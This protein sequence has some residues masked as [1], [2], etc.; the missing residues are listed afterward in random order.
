M[1]APVIDGSLAEWQWYHRLDAVADGAVGY[2]LYGQFSGGNYVFAIS[3]PVAITNATTIWLDTDLNTATGYQVFGT[4]VGAEY[5][6]N[7]VGGLPYLYTGAAAQNFVSGPLTH[8]FSG[9][10]K[11]LEVS[12]PASSIGST[13]ALRVF[14]DVNDSVFLPND[15]TFTGY[16]VEAL[17][18]VVSDSFTGSNGTLL[19]SHAADTGDAWTLRSGSAEIQS[20]KLS[21]STQPSIFTLSALVPASADYDVSVDITVTDAQ[22]AIGVTGRHSTSATTF[23]HFRWLNG[24]YELYSFVAGSP[25]LLSTIAGA[26]SVSDVARLRLRMRGTTISGWVNGV[27]KVSVTDSTITATGVAGFRN[28][29]N[30]GDAIYDN[31]EVATPWTG[32]TNVT[33]VQT[34]FDDA[35][36]FGTSVVSPGSVTLV[37]TRFSDADSFGTSVIRLGATLVG[38]LFVDADTF[39]TSVVS[40]GSMTLEQVRFDDEDLFGA[41]SFIT[42]S[43][44]PFGAASWITVTRVAANIWI[45]IDAA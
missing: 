19:A 16:K 41:D 11:I 45:D 38:T 15:Y 20:N 14:I 36:A 31:Y 23:Y 1:T 44:S 9:D 37:Q 6:V 26:L 22:N 13:T 39:G 40:P 42:A 12:V 18:I 2:A 7:I 3:A 17:D 43:A 29:N 4:A 33:C 8:A 27:Q 28:N 25:T 30:A 21:S 35:D 34:R 5:N 24:N 32:A 10:S